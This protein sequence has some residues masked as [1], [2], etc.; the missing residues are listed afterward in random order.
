M[1][2]DFEHATMREMQAEIERLT[3]ENRKM[4]AT[5]ATD[6]ME[7]LRL[8]A[9]LERI[10]ANGERGGYAYG[11][12]FA[13][14]NANEQRTKWCDRCGQNVKLEWVQEH[15]CQYFDCPT[16]QSVT[17]LGPEEVVNIGGK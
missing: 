6:A 12:A 4:N 8:R 15:N 1:K 3:D 10:V 13:A 11:V 7:I 17:V 16:E 2:W 5:L 9:A 14:L